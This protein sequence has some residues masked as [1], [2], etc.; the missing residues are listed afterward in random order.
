MENEGTTETTDGDGNG[1]GTEEESTTTT[2][3]TEKGGKAEEGEPS[4]DQ[5]MNLEE[6][7]HASE[8]STQL[9]ITDFEATTQAGRTLE[10]NTC[11]GCTSLELMIQDPQFV[12]E[13]PA[14]TTLLYSQQRGTSV[15]SSLSGLSNHS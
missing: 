7:W 15:Q 4:G 12:S 1:R 10:W 3:R 5:E 9:G 2:A 13:M 11:G 14:T 6:D 8:T